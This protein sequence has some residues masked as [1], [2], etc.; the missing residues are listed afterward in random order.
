MRI[1]PSQL[2]TLYSGSKVNSGTVNLT[3]YVTNYDIIILK[4]KANT[5]T[6]SEIIF[7]PVAGEKCAL[8]TTVANGSGQVTEPYYYK[9]V[10]YITFSSDAKSFT[11]ATAYNNG[12]LVVGVIAV[13]GIKI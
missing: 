12:N 11:Y 6:F 1:P 10:P 4:L 7:R 3:D 5:E 2:N 13:Y 9:N 8:T